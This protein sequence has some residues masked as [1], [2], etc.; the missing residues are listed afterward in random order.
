MQFPAEVGRESGGAE[1]FLD[2]GFGDGGG[3]E[4]ESFGDLFLEQA[5]QSGV[6]RVWRAGRGE[7]AD[8]PEGM[9]DAASGF[10]LA[11]AP[12]IGGDCVGAPPPDKEGCPCQQGHALG[13]PE[14]GP[15]EQWRAAGGEGTEVLFEAEDIACRCGW[16]TVCGRFGGEG[17]HWCGCAGPDLERDGIGG[18]AVVGAGFRVEIGEVEG[19]QGA[20]AGRLGHH[21]QL[22]G[23]GALDPEGIGGLDVFG[24][25]VGFESVPV[26]LLG[27]FEC[28]EHAV[29]A[30]LDADGDGVAHS[31]VGGAGHEGEGEPTHCAVEFGWAILFRQGQ[32]PDGFGVGPQRDGAGLAE[33]ENAESE[34]CEGIAASVFLGEFGHE[35]AVQ[36]PHT[37]GARARG[38]KGVDDGDDGELTELISFGALGQPGL[39]ELGAGFDLQGGKLHVG[40]VFDAVTQAEVHLDCEG[41]ADEYLPFRQDEAEV[42]QLGA[43]VATDD[44]QLKRLAGQCLTVHA[45]LDGGQRVIAGLLAEDGVLVRDGGADAAVDHDDLA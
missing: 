34:A 37:E 38:D 29:A 15:G 43:G 26:G 21:D 20:E 39:F 16:G 36:R 42:G 22:E 33:P 11:L 24:G 45:H 18:D 14:G 32:D 25:R 40:D 31:D 8:F 4:V 27:E 44:F 28:L 9:A 1:S 10:A 35:A 13:E 30:D 5:E 7:V 3:G 23:F 41:F 2:D 6:E 17:G 19:R 12:W